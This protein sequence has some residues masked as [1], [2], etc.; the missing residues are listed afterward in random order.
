MGEHRAPGPPGWPLIGNLIAFRR[1][2]LGL[3]LDSRR[4]YGDV[5]RFRLGPM[6]IH[7]VAHPEQIEVR[8][9]YAELQL[10]LG[11]RREAHQLYESLI[12]DAQER[13][14]EGNDTLIAVPGSNNIIVVEIDVTGQTCTATASFELKPGKTYYTLHDGNRLYG[15]GKP[16]VTRT[17]CRIR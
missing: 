12:G 17:S 14:T 2:V 16:R 4:R 9:H 10:R 5:V 8:S 7:L 15:C 3:L 13:G 1:D 6:V 11:R